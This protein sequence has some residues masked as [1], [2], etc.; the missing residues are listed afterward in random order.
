MLQ[1]IAK[2]L[3]SAEISARLNISQSTVITHRRNLMR[4]LGLH[5]AAELTAYAIKNK[6]VS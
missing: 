6:I 4:K 3:T 1:L 2:G 5:S